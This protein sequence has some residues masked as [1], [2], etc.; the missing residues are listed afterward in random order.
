VDY[1]KLAGR[2]LTLLNKYGQP[3]T[4]RPVG[5]NADYDP[6]NGSIDPSVDA[7]TND[8]IRNVLPTDQPGNRVAQRFG[9]T[10]QNGTLIQ[11]T[12]KWMYM[13]AS[14]TLPKLQD[15]IFLAGIN[16]SI[17]DVQVVSPGVVPL[18]YLLVCRA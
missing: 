14:G 9:Q 3:A 7:A 5:V 6:S 17:I 15:H 2:V 18:L 10:L 1:N 11:N 8:E 4:L 13:D 12:D 16:F